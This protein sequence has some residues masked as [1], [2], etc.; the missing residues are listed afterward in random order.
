MSHLIVRVFAVPFALDGNSNTLG[1]RDVNVLRF[2][3]RKRWMLESVVVVGRFSDVTKAIGWLSLPLRFTN[4]ELFAVVVSGD[5]G[6]WVVLG[7][8]RVVGHAQPLEKMR[9]FYRA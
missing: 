6:G 7:V 9:F 2:G 8:E 5:G 3:G 4:R 1:R